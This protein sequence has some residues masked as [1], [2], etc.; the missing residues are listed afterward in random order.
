LSEPGSL[1]VWGN[2]QSSEIGLTDQIVEENKAGYRKCSMRQPVKHPMFNR[3]VYNVAPG[4]V[5][6]LFHCVN[7]ETKDT[8]VVMCGITAMAKA[9]EEVENNELTPADA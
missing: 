4:N 6:T 3:I 5:N 7:K 8:F 1:Y 9:G 2:N